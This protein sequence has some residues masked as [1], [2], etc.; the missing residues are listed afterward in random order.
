MPT[1]TALLFVG[2]PR[3]YSP[4]VNAW[5]FTLEHFPPS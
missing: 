3:L 4:S 1:I 5:V 2:L